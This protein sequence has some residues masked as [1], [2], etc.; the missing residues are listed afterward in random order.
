MGP[1][2][3]DL[4]PDGTAGTSER[5][6]LPTFDDFPTTFRRFS[7]GDCDLRLKASALSVQPAQH[8]PDLS[9]FSAHIVLGGA[10]QRHR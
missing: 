4:G 9:F 8:W 1:V 5:C 10:L 2:G 7:V 6:P 3:P